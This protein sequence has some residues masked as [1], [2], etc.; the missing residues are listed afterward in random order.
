MFRTKL[1]LFILSFVVLLLSI[2]TPAH[3]SLVTYTDP[4]SFAN[5]TSSLTQV[6][7]T[8]LAPAGSFKDYSTS[9]GLL[10]DGVDFV[11]EYTTYSSYQ[12]DVYDSQYG[13]PY[14][15]WGSGPVLRGPVYDN[16]SPA[17]LP[18]I[19]VTLPTNT[20][21]FSV[22]LMTL[23]PNGLT[24]QITLPGGATYTTPTAS[25]PT[26]TFFGLTSDTA[27]SYVDFTVLGTSSTGGTYG[28]MDNFQFGT[29]STSDSGDTGG[30]GSDVPEVGTLVL[31]GTG[32]IAFRMI[33]RHGSADTPAHA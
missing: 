15:N 30:S 3:A 28:L 10:M 17:N 23:S 21:A 8:G 16:A 22:N 32:L 18:Y 9:T 19:Q 6:P 14:Y 27:I 11:G 29:A 20:T 25:R 2:A 5:A 26:Q 12:L 7:L 24:Y 33:R 31:I 4:T 1:Q 13:S